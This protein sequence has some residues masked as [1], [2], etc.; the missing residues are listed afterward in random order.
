MNPLLTQL[1]DVC[2]RRPSQTKWVIL[3]SLRLGHTIAERLTRLGI[4]W[5]NIRWTTPDDLA[6]A[7]AGPILL[8]RHVTL[9]SEGSGAL[10]LMR[11]MLRL[12]ATIPAYFRHMAHHAPM[13]EALWQTISELRMAGGCAEALDTAAWCTSTDKQRELV[14]LIRAYEAYMADHRVADRARLYHE[15]LSQGLS[16]VIQSHELVLE[17]P[18]TLWAPLQRRLLDALVG[19]RIPPAERELPGLAPPR[20][21]GALAAKTARLVGS[22]PSRDSERLA[23]LLKPESAPPPQEDGSVAFFCTGSRE[24]EVEEIFRRILANKVP[25]DEVEIACASAELVSL[26]WEKAH[27]HG[28]PVT[29]ASGLP[30]TFSRPGRALLALCGW[31]EDNFP[32]GQLR[33]MLQS[34]DIVV[35]EADGPTPGQAA[36]VLATSAC[37]WGRA[38]YEAAL[39]ALVQSYRARA[40]DDPDI[41]PPYQRRIRHVEHVRAW[42]RTLLE[43]IPQTDEQHEAPLAPWLDMFQFFLDEYVQKTT[44]MDHQAVAA[45]REV[46]R[47]L[48]VLDTVPPDCDVLTTVRERIATLRILAKGPQPGHLF[49]TRLQD[50]GET[51][52]RCTFLAGAEEGSV[53]PALREDAVLLDAERTALDPLLRTSQD[54]V[55]ESL[56]QL[57]TR[58]AGLSGDITVSYASYD[59]RESRETFPS[60]IVLQ[61]WRLLHPGQTWTYNGLKASFGAP[62]S[63][64]P[65]PPNLSP[66]DACWWLA[67]LS[68]QGSAARDAVLRAFPLL[69]AGARAAQARASEQYTEY[70]GWVPAAHIL[71]PAR[72][73]MSASATSL[74]TLASCPFRYFLSQGLNIEGPEDRESTPD[75]WLDAAT[76]GQILHQLYA[77]ALRERRRRGGWTETDSIAWLER[78]TQ[79]ELGRLRATARPPSEDVY[80]RESAALLKD[81]AVFI[82]LERQNIHH[83][84]VGLEVG[85]GMAT[86]GEP[87]SSADPVD[88]PLGIK[89]TI[90][91]RGR[92]DRIDRLPDGTYEVMDYKTGRVRLKGDLN[93]TFAGGRQLQ[94]ALYA[95]AAA[96]LL[97]RQGVAGHISRSTYYFPTQR[98]EGRRLE[99][100][101]DS[102]A[103]HAVMSDLADLIGSGVFPQTTSKEDCK[104]C[105]Y[106]RTCGSEPSAASLRK[107]N[108]TGLIVLNPYRKLAGHA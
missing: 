63:L 34:G 100:T 69:T 87:L 98:G 4:A 49:V 55:S 81:I 108:N 14:A 8:S 46:L 64:V 38:T 1:A 48:R 80:G 84:T 21:L 47:D 25:L 40:C 77:E 45:L 88:I 39:S 23:F 11:V 83:E 72:S 31:I 30:V 13:A 32:A 66:S 94:H 82:Q 18:H 61:A 91:L 50:I 102:T 58:L 20:R 86:D 44:E 53:L 92:I 6:G 97:R 54:Q 78:R 15:A 73:G 67:V 89:G 7:V 10:V 57:V 95:L 41:Q 42:I 60:W 71:N 35:N 85:F 62:A 104:Y 99:R 26:I 103:T 9:L 27:R 101:V 59:T 106:T 5:A 74:E 76:R 22:V 28:W 51:G 65:R 2:V 79:E 90:K 56:Y 43:Q 37:T 33:R 36:R 3:P 70:D 29:V 12:P 105:E 24:A 96:E 52:R 19:I 93:G 107:V 75:A 68:G 17:W 16:S